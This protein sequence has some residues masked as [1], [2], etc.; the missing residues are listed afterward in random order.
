M[1]QAFR[2]CKWSGLTQ[3]PG[4]VTLNFRVWGPSTNLSPCIQPSFVDIKRPAFY[5]QLTWTNA[6]SP[7]L[8][9]CLLDCLIFMFFII[10]WPFSNSS[11]LFVFFCI[12]FSLDLS[13]L[14][15]IN[16]EFPFLA[17]FS[18][19]STTISSTALSQFLLTGG[20]SPL[21]LSCKW[22]ICHWV[23]TKRSKEVV[24]ILVVMFLT[25]F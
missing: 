23:Q 11:S 17:S 9:C 24:I 22:Y 12:F 10:V 21:S 5:L 25:V 3:L 18:D 4:L 1:L 19:N 16:H 14:V 2:L 6:L 15:T 8:S 13:W 20:G 7:D